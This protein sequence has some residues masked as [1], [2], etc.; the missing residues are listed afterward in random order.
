MS[1]WW[2]NDVCRGASSLRCFFL[3][4]LDI[5]QWAT[6]LPAF[7]LD[8]L[9]SSLIELDWHLV[10]STVL[11]V[12]PGLECRCASIPQEELSGARVALLQARVAGIERILGISSSPVRQIRQKPA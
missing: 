5:R 3:G 10:A 12:A 7:L 1:E 6:P 8:L 2:N 11:Q 9:R 4:Y